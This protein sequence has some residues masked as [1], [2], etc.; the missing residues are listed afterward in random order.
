MPKKEKVEVKPKKR[1]V[2]KVEKKVEVK[3][4]SV[5]INVPKARVV[6][7]V[8]VKVVTVPALPMF[9]NKRVL[10][11][12]DDGRHTDTHYHCDMEGG[13]KM[14]VPKRLFHGV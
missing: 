7:K 14:H 1:V 3:E 4:S 12:L 6:A 9:D 8:E 13:V 2:K 11:I 10:K 5:V